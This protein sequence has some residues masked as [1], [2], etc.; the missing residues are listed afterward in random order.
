VRLL[1]VTQYFWPENFR[2]NDLV[3]ALV[4]RGHEVVVA[5]GLPNYPG[6]SFHPGY[7]LLAWRRYRE[8]YRGARVV[9]FPLLPRGGAGAARLF[10]NYLSFAI[11][12]SLL[13][14][15]WC[16]GRF[17]AIF[18]HEVSPITVALPALVMKWLKRTP[19]LLWVLDL[20]PEAWPPP[21]TCARRSSCG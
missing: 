17:D 14:P 3:D 15:L 5:T 19:M 11:S 21:A 1:V 20:W 18:V 13:A 4:A 12:A 7:G 8:R 10:A 6:G 2:V 16:R 9:R